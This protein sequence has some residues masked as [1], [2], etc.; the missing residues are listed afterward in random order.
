[1]SDCHIVMNKRIDGLPHKLSSLRAIFHLLNDFGDEL[2]NWLEW[3][4]KH[5][6]LFFSAREAGHLRSISKNFSEGTGVSACLKTD[7]D[8]EFLR[9]EANSNIASDAVPF[10]LQ[11]WLAHTKSD[12]TIE[13]EWFNTMEKSSEK[14]FD[15]GIARITR[16]DIDVDFRGYSPPQESHEIPQEEAE[17]AIEATQIIPKGVTMTVRCSLPQESH[18]IP[19]RETAP[20]VENGLSGPE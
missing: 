14:R 19:Q 7:G 20:A 13:I 1:M 10:V 18:E 8:L 9:I 3:D 17:A 12:E 16:N 4:F 15:S 5:R 6:G 11:F 2:G